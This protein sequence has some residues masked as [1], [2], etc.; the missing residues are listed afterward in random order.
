MSVADPAIVR[1]VAG[2]H[3]VVVVADL[4]YRFGLRAARDRVVLADLVAVAD[5]QIAALAGEVL[6]ERIGA[7]HGAGR[8]LV[9]LAERGPALDVDVRLE[10]AAGADDDVRLDHAVFA[11]DAR[12]P[13]TASGCTRAVGATTAEGSMGMNLY[14]KACASENWQS[15]SAPTFEGDGEKE[16][17]RR[18][19]ARDG[20]RGDVVLRR[21]PQGRARRRKLRRPAA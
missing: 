14:H 20:G 19:A 8:D 15:G 1:D 4:G 3:D 17:D 5:A 21:Q 18:R 12:G 6:V 11:D 16:L 7:E 9:A 2:G 13:I 10:P